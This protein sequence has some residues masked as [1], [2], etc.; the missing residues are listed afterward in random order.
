MRAGR[1]RHLVWVERPTTTQ[2]ASGEP[3]LTW[4][5]WKQLRC[6]IEP[7]Q[8]RERFEAQQV[9]PEVTHQVR[10][11]YVHGLSPRDRLRYDG[12]TLNISELTNVNERN[13]EH[14]LLCAEEL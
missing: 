1:M 9:R 12:R 5:R 11:R 3:V 8:G 4:E 7:L 2:T 6:Q 13:R 14:L 10:M